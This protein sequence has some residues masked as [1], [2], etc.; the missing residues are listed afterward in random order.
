LEPL[1]DTLKKDVLSSDYI[2]IDETPIPVMDK[3]HP[4]A[5]K[6]GYHWIIRAPQMR[7]LYFHYDGGSR[8]RRVA[9]D[10]LKDFKGAVQSDGYSAYDIYENRKDVLLLGC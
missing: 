8:S 9:V 3:D 7:K 6:K 1:H 2:Q 5:T 10:I 4:G